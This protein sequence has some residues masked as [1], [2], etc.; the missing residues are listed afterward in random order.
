MRVCINTLINDSI[1][2]EIRT[3]FNNVI[4]VKHEHYL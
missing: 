1:I 2:V 3:H 4:V